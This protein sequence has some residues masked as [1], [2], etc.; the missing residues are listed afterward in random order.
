MS[1]RL[2][3]QNQADYDRVADVRTSGRV[4]SADDLAAW[5]AARP[6]PSEAIDW[7]PL[8]DAAAAFD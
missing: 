5:L 1:D 4:R 6:D 2:Q 8:Y 7:T 3:P